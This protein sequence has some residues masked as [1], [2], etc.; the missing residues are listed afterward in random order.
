MCSIYKLL[1]YFFF[2]G[3]LMAKILFIV[4]RLILRFLGVDG[5]KVYLDVLLYDISFRYRLTL[6]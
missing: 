6:T 3:I 2:I 4:M 1:G 5:D